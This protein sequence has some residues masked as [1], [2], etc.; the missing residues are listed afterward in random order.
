[1]KPVLTKI[2]STIAGAIVLVIG[3]AMAG[4]GL[5]VL[6]VLAMF[7]MAALGLAVLARPFLD[8]AIA[9]A[10]EEQGASVQA[11]PSAA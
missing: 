3:C 2:T 10:A 6:A 5:S 11:N 7:A 9:K 1:M 8:T 4:L